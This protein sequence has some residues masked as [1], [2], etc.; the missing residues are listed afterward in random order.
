MGCMR[1]IGK[2]RSN[3]SV[4][5][6]A[7]LRATSAL[8]TSIPRCTSPSKP[9]KLTSTRRSR[10]WPTGH[11]ACHAP[12]AT[13]RAHWVDGTAEITAFAVTGAGRGVGS[14]VGD[15][16]AVGAVAAAA[17]APEAD[18][19]DGV[20]LGDGA[21]GSGRDGEAEGGTGTA[22]PLTTRRAAATR[23]AA[24]RAL[25]GDGV[26]GGGTAA[27]A[28]GG[29][30]T[31]TRLAAAAPTGMFSGATGCHEHDHRDDRR[32]LSPRR[33]S[34][35]PRRVGRHRLPWC[36]LG[37]TW[38]D[39]ALAERGRGDPVLVRHRLFELNPDLPAEGVPMAGSSR[40]VRQ[41]RRRRDAHAR[42]DRHG[43]GGGTRLRLR[44]RRQ[45]AEHPPRPPRA[46][47]P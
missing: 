16:P 25:C 10:D 28:A 13:I 43:P 31:R 26:V 41:L 33:R 4:N 17:T 42:L 27:R 15:E 9:W 29:R 39:L 30:V 12:T 38:L 35:P 8:T 44:R 7:T 32:R 47:P 22:H 20:T 23:T 1:R 40:P 21:A 45:G 46:R 3:S 36:Y 34:R 11:P 5:T 2:P 18:V 19:T 6:A 24:R 37:S 14:L